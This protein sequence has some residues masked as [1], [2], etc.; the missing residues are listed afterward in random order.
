[1]GVERIEPVGAVGAGKQAHAANHRAGAGDAVDG[2]AALVDRAEADARSGTD[3][4]ERAADAR[5]RGMHT[6]AVVLVPVGE[7]LDLLVAR[8]HNAVRRCEILAARRRAGDLYL[9]VVGTDGLAAS[10]VDEVGDWPVRVRNPAARVAKCLRQV[11]GSQIGKPDR[12]PRIG[13]REVRCTGARIAGVEVGGRR[14]R[15][16][17]QG[18]VGVRPWL[19]GDARVVVNGVVLVSAPEEVVQVVVVEVRHLVGVVG[20][21]VLRRA[22]RLQERREEEVHPFLGQEFKVHGSRVV[23]VHHDV[24]RDLVL[25]RHRHIG[26]V[27]RSGMHGLR[28]LAEDEARQRRQ[29]GRLA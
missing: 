27:G 3:A 13:H 21:A 17:H 10:V 9:G 20:A 8:A 7:V 2:R 23:Q 1:M 25:H 18:T 22:A 4:G 15:D 28:Q 5:A 26:D 14:D 11:A 16:R 24:R 19:V 6:R 29:H 12:S